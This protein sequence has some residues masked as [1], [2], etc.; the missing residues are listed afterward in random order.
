MID[1]SKE[2]LISLHYGQGLTQYEIADVYNC[3]RATIKRRFKKYDIDGINRGGYW[4][5]KNYVC[6]GFYK[7]GSSVEYESWTEKDKR[8]YVHQ[9]LACVDNDPHEVFASNN[10]V[11]HV[12][13]I[14]IDNRHDN[15][16]VID[17]REHARIHANN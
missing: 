17:K 13:G 6:H 5:K 14:S 2:E 7:H 16:V 4:N 11:H 15:I 8:V 1:I 12:N 10:H 3:S 9:L